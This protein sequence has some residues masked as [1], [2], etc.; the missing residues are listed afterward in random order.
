MKRI[1]L[2]GLLCFSLCG[3]EVILVGTSYGHH[4]TRLLI[5]QVAVSDERIYRH[6]NAGEDIP[7]EKL[8][9]C[10]LLVLA[11]AIKTPLSAE[12]MQTLRQWVENGGNLVLISH[13]AR[14]ASPPKTWG[15]A[16]FSNY[17]VTTRD[18]F[19]VKVMNRNSPL[20]NGL[21]L[22]EGELFKGGAAFVPE[23][24][25][26]VV[27]GDT[28]RCSVGVTKVGKGRVF[29]LGQE[30]FRLVH[31]KVSFAGNHLK[32]LQNIFAMA[33]PASDAD[34]QKDLLADWQKKRG[35][36][37][38][39][40]R[41]WQRGEVQGPRFNPPLP[42]EKELISQKT[43]HLA[44]NEFETVQINL[45]PLET[46]REVGWVL[47]N[48]GFPAEKL[49]FLVQDA[50]KPIPWPRNPAIVK[51]FPYWL[52]P[53][54]YLEPEGKPEFASSAVGDTKIVWLR[55]NTHGVAAGDYRP[56][57]KLTFDGRTRVEIPFQVKVAKTA[58]PAKRRIQLAVG[59]YALNSLELKQN[60]RFLDDLRDHGNE[61]GMISAQ[62]LR[63]DKIR[64]AGTDKVLSV[65][66]LKGFQSEN[67]PKLDFSV[68]DEWLVACL[69]RNL[70]RFRVN[71]PPTL[72]TQM[73]KAG[74]SDERRKS[75]NDW[76]LREFSAYMHGKGIRMLLTS[77]GDE[78]NRNELY[79][80]WLP[81]AKDM[82]SFGFDCTSTFSFGHGDYQQLVK[83]LSPY[84][85]LW[86]LNRG[87]APSF[88]ARIKSGE[89]SIRPDAL[90]GTYGAGEGRGSEFRK[91][92]SASRF[93]GWESWKIGVD[94]CTPNPWFKS[95]LYY[96]D[97]G[98][99]GQA[100]GIGG[101]RWVSYV[102]REN[103]DIP[104]A[105]CPF[106]E[107]VRDGMEE[108]NLAALLEA[109]AKTLGRQDLL[110]K[111]NALVSDH[112]DA[113]VY[114]K[115]EQ[116]TQRENE[117]DFYRVKAGVEGYRRAKSEILSMLDSL[118]PDPALFWHR[119]DLAKVEL[120]GDPEAIRQFKSR[121]KN[122]FGIDLESQPGAPVKIRFQ[123]NPSVKSGDYH[124]VE[125]NAE[126]RVESGDS[127]G[128]QL[129]VN[130]FSAF[131]NQHGK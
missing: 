29:V 99:R 42:L 87:L 59:G 17:L 93:L 69:S 91:P 109:R 2:F 4:E 88:L 48:G 130:M 108:G 41:E 43:L 51:E 39:W 14:T 76:F 8:P 44:R 127:A 111:L 25:M 112:P 115:L 79:S 65:A 28:D 116:R 32:I 103:P 106:W 64:F 84:V 38:V 5:N 34:M 90:V 94:R 19:P 49:E 7:F 63:P 83:D 104:P 6:E 35:G 57:L 23:A 54:Q 1:A 107:G 45:T 27:L 101:E 71:I 47:E 20:L 18:A 73:K 52:I 55:F 97:Y 85:R 124:I 75:V 66:E 123:I 102:D 98:T 72:E 13:I 67:P 21:Q 114:G 15:W 30:Y 105:D 16:G 125:N 121:V 92:L 46:F 131:L 10:S 96:C 11:T 110:E 50:P 120:N 113:P 24:S 22:P 12:Q 56:L 100:G 40:D 33:D 74:F 118:P 60:H 119:V 129:G 78:L 37:L 36:V 89:I 117:F 31:R 126:L 53:P 26:D 3:G 82:T 70:I 68:L 62:A 128:L 81:W 58:V 122:A 80:N 9:G 95:W 86:T 77:K 61:W